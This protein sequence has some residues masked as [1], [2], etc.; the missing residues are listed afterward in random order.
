M[1]YKGDGVPPGL[2][3][4]GQFNKS[5]LWRA[6]SG[7]RIGYPKVRQPG[8]LQSVL[9]TGSC[10]VSHSLNLIFAFPKMI[11][12]WHLWRFSKSYFFLGAARIVIEWCPIEFCSAGDWATCP[13]LSNSEIFRVSTAV[14]DQSKSSQSHVAMALIPSL[15]SFLV[16]G[17]AHEVPDQ[18]YKA[19]FG[20]P[21]TLNQSSLDNFVSCDCGFT[22]AQQLGSSGIFQL[23]Q[24]CACTVCSKSLRGTGET[25]HNGVDMTSLAGS[26]ILLPSGSW[27]SANMNGTNLL[28]CTSAWRRS[29]GH[30][31][32]GAYY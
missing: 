3:L 11:L 12:D 4:P 27:D 13:T 30:G 9:G 26:K 29:R 2:S 16:L 32:R 28:Y 21:M 22:C 17:W 1:Y 23:A 24:S 7:R 25:S 8:S 10:Y 31:W 15:L 5:V 18:A 14:F 6:R 20:A 19:P